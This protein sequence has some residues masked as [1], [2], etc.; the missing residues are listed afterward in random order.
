M[1]DFSIERDGVEITVESNKNKDQNLPCFLEKKDENLIV[2]LPYT[3][4]E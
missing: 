3:H 2:K 1:I 4:D